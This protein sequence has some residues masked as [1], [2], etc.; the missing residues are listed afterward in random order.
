MAGS[1][2]IFAE[3]DQVIL[4]FPS[5]G[6]DLCMSPDVGEKVAEKGLA[7]C[8]E[9]EAWM[10]S[11]GQGN[12]VKGE[13]ISCTRPMSWDGKINIRF[14]KDADRIPIPYKVA[15]MLFQEIAAKVVEARHN[16]TIVDRR[17]AVNVP[18]LARS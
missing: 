18:S 4:A 12:V 13:E 17:R 2:E 11:G 3:K 8:D 6:R 7:A 14:N 5:R 16:L 10:N 15:R 9:C 1:M